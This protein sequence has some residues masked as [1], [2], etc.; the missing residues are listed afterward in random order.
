MRANLVVFLLFLVGPKSRAHA[1][2]DA[3]DCCYWGSV[4]IRLGRVQKRLEPSWKRLDTVLE[5]S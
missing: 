5:P 3:V 1:S 2:F 4:G